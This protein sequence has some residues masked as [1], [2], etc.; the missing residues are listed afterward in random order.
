MLHILDSKKS[1]IIIASLDKAVCIF[2]FLFFKNLNNLLHQINK[3][4]LPK[5]KGKTVNKIA[6]VIYT[7]L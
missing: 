4:E 2:L 1:L 5:Q 7:I 3:V 6:G